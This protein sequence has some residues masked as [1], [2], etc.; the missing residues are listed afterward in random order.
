[1]SKLILASASPRRKE[2][3]E[4]I[5]VEFHIHAVDMD[6]S[7]LPGESV[8]QHVERL[9]IEKARLGYGQVSQYEDDLAVLAADTVVE[10]DGDVLGKPANAQ[11]AAVFLTRLS[12]KQHRVHTAVAVVTGTREL[13]EIS[14]SEVV[15]AMLSEQQ[16]AAYVA[17]GEPLDKAGA[18]A[19]QGIAAQFIVNLNGSYSGVMGL[20]L[21]ETAKL[22]SACGLCCGI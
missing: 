14:S 15:F 7:M 2:L 6:E 21:Y 11:Q 17:T 13:I 8:L 19:I 16:I 10:I 3:L 1:M 18:Y 12:G 5:G 22:L 4:Q 9:A 20:P